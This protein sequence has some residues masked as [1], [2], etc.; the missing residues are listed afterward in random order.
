MA[1]NT[2]NIGKYAYTLLHFPSLNLSLIT[3]LNTNPTV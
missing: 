1:Q 2:M 3:F